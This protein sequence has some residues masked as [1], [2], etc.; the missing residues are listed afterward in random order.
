MLI[1]SLYLENVRCIRKANIF[2]GDGVNLFLGSNGSGKSSLLESVHLLATGKSFRTSK[3]DGIKNFDSDN[4][5]ISSKI[6]RNGLENVV[7]FRKH[8]SNVDIRVNTKTISR[9][10]ELVVNFSLITFHS[11]SIYIIDGEP[12]YRRRYIDWWLFQSNPKF[13]PEWLRYQKLLK[14]RNAALRQNNNF[15]HVWDEALAESGEIINLLRKSA[16]EILMHEVITIIKNNYSKQL[17]EFSWQYN[18]GW[19]K[20]ETLLSAL[21]RNHQRDILY[22]FTSVGVHRGDLR[23]SVHG[24]DVKEFLSRGQQKTLSLIL[25]IA[26]A[27][28]HKKVLHET[29]IFMADDISSELDNT[30]RYNLIEQIIDFGGQLFL[31]AINEKDLTFPINTS[32]SSFVLQKGEVHVL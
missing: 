22:G 29:P 15:L 32:V 24:K 25:L 19:P 10:S 27:S 20:G 18:S 30:H 23:F 21:K 6:K 17:S 4:F 8:K 13:Y 1:N 7:G 3:L 26:L 31:T 5:T 16:L 28:I 9:L 12:Q 11:N 14:Q 2:F